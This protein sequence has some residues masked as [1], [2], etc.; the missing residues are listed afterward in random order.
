MLI[1][2]KEIID[3]I[4]SE[5]TLGEI[6]KELN[7]PLS[8]V[9]ER[10][11]GLK[12]KGVLLKRKIYDNGKIRYDMGRHPMNNSCSADIKLCDKSKFSAMLIS[13]LHFGNEFQSLDYLE[14]VYDYVRN[15]GINIIINCGD[16]IDGAFSK[17][18]Q[19]IKNPLDQLNYLISKHPFDERILNLICLGN[20]D[21]SL[22]KSGVDM[23]KA[24]EDARFDLIPLGFGIG[25]LNFDGE[26]IFLKHYI[27]DYSFLPING[28]LVLEGHKHKMALMNS[29]KGFLVDIPTLSNL[30]LGKYE[31]PGAIRMDL[32]FDN[33]GYISSGHFEQFIINKRLYTVNESILDLS[34]LDHDYVFESEIRPKIKSLNPTSSQ[35]DKF[36]RKWRR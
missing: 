13:D 31:F 21:F 7:I 5:K 32:F 19:I 4:N 9:H 1:Y 33:D 28:K 23:K 25:I 2:D 8:L 18:N 26:Q 17:G 30:V 29:D 27:S 16:L 14:K 12:N 20:H 36:N 35:I 3:K 24:L 6:A 11:M 34:Y 22:Y 15:N 10:V